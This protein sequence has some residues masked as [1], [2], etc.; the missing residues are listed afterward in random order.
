[1]TPLS[2]AIR[3]YDAAPSDQEASRGL[4]QIAF[5][6]EFDELGGRTPSRDASVAMSRDLAIARELV[7]G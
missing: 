1:M 3:V 7:E 5:T 2:A 6:I 4:D